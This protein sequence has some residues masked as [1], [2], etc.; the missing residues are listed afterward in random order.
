[1]PCAQ[2]RAQ[3]WA[4]QMPA[5]TAAMCPWGWVVAPMGSVRPL[6]SSRGFC[7]P[8]A[9]RSC[10]SSPIPLHP[11]TPHQGRAA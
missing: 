6:C 3:S 9:E 5:V 2:L 10:S 8:A 11:A 7:G 4:L 1:M